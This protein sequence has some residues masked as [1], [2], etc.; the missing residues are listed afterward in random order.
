M[1][2]EYNI[3]WLFPDGSIDWD[4]DE[5]EIEAH[6][7]RVKELKGDDDEEEIDWNNDTEE[8]EADDSE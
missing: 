7:A 4:D 2:D 8:I 3:A 6:D 5:E 1:S